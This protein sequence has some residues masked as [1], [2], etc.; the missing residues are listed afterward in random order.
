[1]HFLKPDGS[2]RESCVLNQKQRLFLTSDLA[3]ATGQKQKTRVHCIG[4]TACVA[5]Y[6]GDCFD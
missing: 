4:S 3:K 6:S 2:E 1:M 5:F